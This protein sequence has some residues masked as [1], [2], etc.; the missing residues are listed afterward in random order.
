MNLYVCYMTNGHD[1]AVELHES[2]EA[3]EKS[4]DL[5]TRYFSEEPWDVT[6]LQVK[7]QEV[8]LFKGVVSLI[9]YMKLSIKSLKTAL[10][11]AENTCPFG[12]VSESYY[13]N[14]TT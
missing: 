5:H 6:I 9:S 1:H 8:K 2:Y 7:N 11:D 4:A 12:C 3:A 13:Q 10:D 14:R